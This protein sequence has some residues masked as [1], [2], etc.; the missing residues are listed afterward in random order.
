MAVPRPRR[1][2]RVHGH[3]DEQ[4]RPTFVMLALQMTSLFLLQLVVSLSLFGG[5]LLA[6]LHPSAKIFSPTRSAPAAA[7]GFVRAIGC[8]FIVGSVAIFVITLHHH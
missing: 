5:G 2:C 6:L 4:R 1:P 3:D 8:L 7:P